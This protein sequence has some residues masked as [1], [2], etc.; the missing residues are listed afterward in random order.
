MAVDTFNFNG[1]TLRVTCDQR[2]VLTIAFDLPGR[3]YNVLTAEVFAELD[4]LLDTLH[5]EAAPGG[6]VRLVA[7]RG[8]KASGFLAGA[9]LRELAS[10]PDAAAAEELSRLGQAVLD[11]IERLRV[12]T[13]A[14]IHGPCLGGGLELALACRHRLALDDQRTQLGAPEVALGLLPAWGGTQRLPRRIGLRAGLAM[15]LEAEKIS[16][17]RALAWG[18]VDRCWPAAMFGDGVARYVAQ[19]LAGPPLRRRSH[20]KGLRTGRGRRA[21]QAVLHAAGRWLPASSNLATAQ[22][23]ALQAVEE[24]LLH[25]RDAGVRAEQRHFGQ[26]LFTPHCQQRLSRFLDRGRRP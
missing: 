11:R 14:V 7:F 19:R 26:L 25:G 6:R 2:G 20:R 3:T 12:P 21:R 15:I 4:R 23:A 1:R 13:V 16:A 10:L 5:A 24:G 22:A 17:P 8:G 18:L 9:D